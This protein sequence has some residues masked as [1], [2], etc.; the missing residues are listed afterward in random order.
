MTIP[1]RE[2]ARYKVGRSGAASPSEILLIEDD[3]MVRGVLCRAL[4][5]TG[6]LV[7]EADTGQRAQALLDECGPVDIIISDVDLPDADGRELVE[8]MA[9]KYPET[10][11][12]LMSGRPWKTT[13]TLLLKPFTVAELELALDC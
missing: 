8:P 2:P 12:V 1:V 7:H 11:I 5:R 3:P 13:R 9:E 4:R 6:Y 10:R